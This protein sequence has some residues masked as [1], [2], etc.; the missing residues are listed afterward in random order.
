MRDM[1]AEVFTH[2]VETDIQAGMHFQW[3]T[4]LGLAAILAI[5]SALFGQANTASIRGIVADPSGA[6]V[7]QADVTLT[8]TGTGVKSAIKTNGRRVSF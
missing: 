4:F 2:P 5:A 1:P 8:N 6:V 7:P 3:R